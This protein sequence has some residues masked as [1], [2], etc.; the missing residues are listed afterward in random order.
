MR[1]CRERLSPGSDGTVHKSSEKTPI[2]SPPH[3]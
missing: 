1:Q 3:E 2:A